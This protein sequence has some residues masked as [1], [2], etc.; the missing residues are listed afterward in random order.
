MRRLG[1]CLLSILVSV[2]AT[3]DVLERDLQYTLGPISGSFGDGQ[4]LSGVGTFFSDEPL[5]FGLGD[6]LVFN[7]LFDRGLQVFDFGRESK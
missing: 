3:A 7:I 6:T 4:T 1:I 2:P 5:V